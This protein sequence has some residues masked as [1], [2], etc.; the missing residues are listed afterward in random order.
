MTK[1]VIIKTEDR[2]SK[3]KL[4]CPPTPSISGIPQAMIR[5]AVPNPEF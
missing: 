2:N 3:F 1:N 5:A 4:M